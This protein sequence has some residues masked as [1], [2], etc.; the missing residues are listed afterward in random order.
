MILKANPALRGV[1]FELPYIID[2]ARALVEAE[3]VA[4]R[5]EVVTGDFFQSVPASGD[6]YI[7]YADEEEWWAMMRFGMPQPSL[8][9]MPPERLERIK[10]EA[11]DLLQAFRDSDGLHYPRRVL[12]TM[13]VKPA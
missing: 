10:A 4:K 5:C 9:G 13:G 2:D 7:L 11:F 1:V 8:E 3:G 6:A 12:Y